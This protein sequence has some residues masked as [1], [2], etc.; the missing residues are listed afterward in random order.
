VGKR[1]RPDY[2]AHRD[3]PRAEGRREPRGDGGDFAAVRGH[4]CFRNVFV[5][6]S[7]D[8]V[9]IFKVRTNVGINFANNIVE[10]KMTIFAQNNYMCYTETQK[11]A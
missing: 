1:G 10:N 4:V 2:R 7:D 9:M 3:D 5:F 6:V 11:R 8:V